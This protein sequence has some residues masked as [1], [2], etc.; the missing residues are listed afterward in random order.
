ME[1]NIANLLNHSDVMLIFT[2][3]AFGLLLGRVRFGDIEL[4]QTAGVLIVALLFGHWGFNLTVHTES[5]GFMLFI[6][7]VG[8]EAGPNFFSSF[9]QD[10]VRY[11]TLA[12]VVAVSGIAMTLGIAHLAELEPGISAGMLAGSLTSSPTLAGAQG[13]AE[14]LVGELG[15]EGRDALVSQIG[16][17]YALTYVI[18]LIGLILMIRALP[19][20]LSLDLP[21]L[22][23]DVAIERGMD[24]GRRRTVRTP[25]IRAYRVSSDIAERIGGRTLRE[26]GI[27]EQN[28][29]SVERVKRDGEL[30]TPDSET[31]LV[32]GDE[33]ALV[34][35]PVSH[36]RSDL[37]FSDEIYD[38]DLL[39]FQIVSHPIVVARTNVIGRELSDLNLI[40]EYGCF[41]SGVTRSQVPLPVENN[42]RLDRGD[43]LEVSGERSSVERLAE[44]LGFIEQASEKS[45]LMTFSS[46]FVFG[47]LLAQLSVL[48]GDLRITLGSAGGLL[49]AGIMLGH[50]RARNP[51]IGH[52]PQSAVNMLKDLGLNIFMVSVGL[53][54]GDS[55]VDVLA[56]SGLLIVGSGLAIMLVPLCMGYLVGHLVLRMNP[57]LLLGAITGAMT[58]TPALNILNDISKSS[59]PALG[60][61]GTYTFANVFLTLGGAAIIS[62]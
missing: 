60:Y 7:C 13:A 5:L 23:R 46:F 53:N 24:T 56:D 55:I 19:R 34:G 36:A 47:L 6:F 3:L 17:G 4:G 30:F 38:A 42:L 54:A 2:V 32:E 52:V 11:I 9:M 45:D 59:I 21:E 27:Q 35:Y 22:A 8:M 37:D 40:S 62:M 33:V 51:I 39:E 20:M 14:R 18:G 15:K 1:I 57:A 48:V 61:A 31:V 44:A 12:A 16:V 29:L 25:I 58:S 41:V 50:M 28:N 43:I 10:G 49:A 26:I